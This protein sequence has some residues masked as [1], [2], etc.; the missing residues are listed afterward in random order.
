[1]VVLFQEIGYF[2]YLTRLI[3]IQNDQNR[4]FLHSLCKKTNARILNSVNLADSINVTGY[5]ATPKKMDNFLSLPIVQK[6]KSF[7]I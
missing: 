7:I 4:S 5:P 3:E 2:C 1:M 6:K